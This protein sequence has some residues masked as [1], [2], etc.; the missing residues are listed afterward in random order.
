MPDVETTRTPATSSHGGTPGRP[1][2]PRI[3]A[4][5]LDATKRLLIEVGYAR[6]SFELVARRAGVT[7]PTIYRRWPSKMHL[8]HAAVFP[9]PDT[10]LVADSGDFEADLR[11]MIR[12]TLRSY[13]RPE[14]QAAIAGLLS[15]LH[16]DPQLRTAVIDR[17]ENQVRA[18]LAA[19]VDRATERGEIAADV[20]A[21][22]LLDTVSGAVFHR[23]VARQL[24]SEQFVD[25]LAHL[26]L[27]GLTP[28]SRPGPSAGP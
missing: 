24:L 3:D 1:R 16:D 8:V 19:V 28:R 4:D 20:D 17:L 23:V 12:R 13:A 2:D 22:T 6:V 25:R 10:T 27:F 11:A 26:L 21:D 14:A 15:D 5:V 9:D 7:R 18:H